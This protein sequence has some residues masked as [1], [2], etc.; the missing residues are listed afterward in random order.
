MFCNVRLRRTTLCPSD[1]PAS[2]SKAEFHPKKV[3][4]SL[5]WDLQGI[6]PWEVQPLNQTINYLLN[7]L[8]VNF[9]NN[10]PRPHGAIILRQKL[11]SFG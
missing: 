5:W 7:R 11:I 4:Q 1:P 9:H 2:T 3:L 8:S 6:I 10:N